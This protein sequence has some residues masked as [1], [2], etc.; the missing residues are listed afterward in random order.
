MRSQTIN[1]SEKRIPDSRYSGWIDDHPIIGSVGRLEDQ[2]G[3]TYLIDA[4]PQI[5]AIFP[6][7]E[8]WLVGDGPLNS[9]LKKQCQDLGISDHVVFWG[10]QNNIP[11]LLSKMDLFISSSLY[12]GLP[13]AVL[14]A[15]DFGVPCIVTDIPGT[16]DIVHDKNVLV[17]GAKD[18]RALASAIIFYLKSPFTREDNGRGECINTQ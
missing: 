17:V 15:M 7:I 14:E 3:Y 12:E 6:N 1:Q 18:S 10:K 8:T 11:S 2:K 9:A 13:T 4:L 5:I 16:R